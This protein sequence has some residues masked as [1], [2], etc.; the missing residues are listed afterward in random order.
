[1]PIIAIDSGGS[2]THIRISDSSGNMIYESYCDGIGKADDN[3]HE[4]LPDFKQN[5]NEAIFKSGFKTEDI[6]S[7]AVNLGGK[8]TTQ[9][10]RNLES[11]FPMCPI[12][13]YRES[14]SYVSIQFAKAL[15]ANAVLLAG[16]GAICTAFDENKIY[17]CGGWGQDISDDGSGYWI[18]LEAIRH[19]L[20]EI[21]GTLPL[22]EL[23]KK[24]TAQNEPFSAVENP[25]ELMQKRDDVRYAIG[26]RTR[27]HIA[28]FA[29]TVCACAHN[30]DN[31]SIDI[32]KKAGYML[33]ELCVN[34]IKKVS[35][36]SGGHL[37]ISGG[38]INSATF[39]EESFRQY[40]EN[41]LP[42]WTFAF[43]A[44]GLIEGTTQIAI[45]LLEEEF[46]HDN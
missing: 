33:A 7:V 18:G 22:S 30:G 45:N 35:S 16:T 13:V 20:R 37:I 39:W 46:N 6:K 17:T 32:L 23:A 44:D 5:V 38:L 1:M 21:D 19:S 43:K 41:N 31:V 3:P 11:I 25:E 28:S 26:E 36:Q 12:A 4:E 10:K 14:S 2:K 27:G 15:G 40:F 9:V 8:N 29:K 34:T 42:D 24:V